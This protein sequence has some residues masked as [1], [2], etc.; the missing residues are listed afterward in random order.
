MKNIYIFFL[1]LF[2][3]G[4]NAQTPVTLVTNLDYPKGLWVK[5]NNVYFTETAQRNTVYGGKFCLDRYRISSGQA[6]VLVSNTENAD[7]VVV[8]NNGKIYLT[9]YLNATPGQQGRVSVVDTAAMTETHLMDIQIA[10]DD[11]FIDAN[12]NISLVGM[13]DFSWANSIYYLPAG[14]YTSPSI[15]QNGLGR[16]W[17]ISKKG[18]NTYFSDLYSTY[19][20]GPNGIVQPFMSKSVVAITFSA[21]YLFYVDYFNGTLGKVN[22]QTMADQTVL[23][24]LHE[25]SNIRYDAGTNSLY[26]LES[27]TNAGQYHDGTLKVLHNVDHVGTGVEENEIKDEVNIYPL[28]FDVSATVEFKN[29]F[30]NEELLFELYD[31]SGKKVKSVQ[32]TEV[33]FLIERENILSGIYFYSVF[34]KRKLTASGKIIVQ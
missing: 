34:R 32:T 21:N 3:F 25:P 23:I 29:H 4:A 8:S 9:S 15:L 18:N 2:S 10:S 12:D 1:L 16:V 31:E 33:K 7:A 6:A 30:P 11:M 22:L 17:C 5:G 20:F 28:P 27:G 19:Y 14:N 24:G 13:S 26:F